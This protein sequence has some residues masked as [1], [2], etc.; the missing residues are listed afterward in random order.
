MLQ[1]L[2]SELG[3]MISWPK[4]PGEKKYK[5]RGKDF[6]NRS[7][8]QKKGRER[9]EK[10][11]SELERMI[12][13]PKSPLKFGRRKEIQRKRER[14]WKQIKQSREGNREKKTKKERD[15]QIKEKKKKRNIRWEWERFRN[16]QNG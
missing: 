1:L 12:S 10:I 14:L 15:F 5:E 9:K 3:K 7:N 8:N 11:R 6:E 4:S 13:W 2:R 16:N